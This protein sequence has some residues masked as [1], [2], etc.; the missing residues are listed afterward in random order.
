MEVKTENGDTMAAEPNNIT[1]SI[2]NNDSSPEQSNFT[3]STAQNDSSSDNKSSDSSES[4]EE[5][6]PSPS[7]V[8]TVNVPTLT[9]TVSKETLKPATATTSTAPTNTE[10]AKRLIIPDMPLNFSTIDGALGDGLL[11]REPMT[12]INDDVAVVKIHSNSQAW[13]TKLTSAF[14]TDYLSNPEDTTKNTP[15]QRDWFTRWQKQAHVTILTIITAKDP[16]HLERSCWYLVDAVIKAHELGVVDAGGNVSPSGL[17]CSERLAFIVSMLEKYALVRRDVLRAWHVD[18]IAANP[19][20]FIKR[21]LVNC[22]NNGHRAEKAKEAKEGKATEKKRAASKVDE[23]AEVQ[24]PFK[25]KKVRKSKADAA[26]D[27][28]TDTSTSANNTRSALTPDSDDKNMESTPSE[29]PTT[30]NAS[31]S[32]IAENDASDAVDAMEED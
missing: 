27:D 23:E 10:D 24:T 18:E 22:W 19:E 9:I 13:V 1:T 20:A 6:L 29:H 28:N 2:A 32:D 3:T 25:A 26:E 8:Q 16:K 21:K 17:K 31:S 12:I 4:S 14:G 5:V 30:L 7:N 15:A 11:G